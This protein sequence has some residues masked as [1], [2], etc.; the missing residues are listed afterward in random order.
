MSTASQRLVII[1]DHQSPVE[2]FSFPQPSTEKYRNLVTNNLDR[3][4][5]KPKNGIVRTDL[6]KSGAD[7]A[8]PMPDGRILVSKPLLRNILAASIGESMFYPSRGIPPPRNYKRIN[9]L[10]RSS[11][12]N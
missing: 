6:K 2:L 3:A 10:P 12:N 8:F 1:L 7:S 5:G 9:I 11:K 4:Y